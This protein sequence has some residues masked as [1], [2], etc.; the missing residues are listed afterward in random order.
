MPQG[1]HID[2][3]PLSGMR[4]DWDV[5]VI[6]E[7]GGTGS[8]TTAARAGPRVVL[9]AH[10]PGGRASTKKDGF[11][12]NRGIHALYQGG[13]GREVLRSLG[14]EPQGSR[15]H[16]LATRPWPAASTSCDEPRFAA[17]HHAPRPEGQGG[18]GRLGRLPRLHPQRHADAAQVMAVTSKDGV[19][20]SVYFVGNPDKLTSVGHSPFIE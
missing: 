4:A 14:I 10:L 11:V 8:G 18:L 1:C 3:R 19:I 17:T 2:R 7:A 5:I 13:P 9:E 16:W 20:T 6:G 15:R 12:F